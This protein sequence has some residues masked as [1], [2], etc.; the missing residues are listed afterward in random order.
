VLRLVLIA[1]AL[2]AVGCNSCSS[3]AV[4]DA[5]A[6]KSRDDVSPVYAQNVTPDPVAQRTCHALHAIHAERRA[7]CCGG[8]P[9]P[10]LAESECVK[11]LSQ[12]L[13]SKAVK[14]DDAKLTA[15]EAAQK[16]Q[17]D[18]CDWPSLD[19]NL[20]AAACW[21][22][23]DGTLAS[24]AVCRSSLECQP[25]LHCGG[26]GPT[27]L[28]HCS[29]PSKPP[30]ACAIA[31]DPLASYTAQRGDDLHPECDGACERHRCVPALDAGQSC[32]SSLQCG[33]NRH[34]AFDGGCAEGGLAR[35]G[36]ACVAGG[37]G[38][39]LRCIGGSCAPAKKSGEACEHDSECTGACSKDAGV[40]APRCR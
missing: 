6:K 39:D 12:S 8:A 2:S 20:P 19:D 14:I 10:N 4:P 9:G 18:G 36:E 13:Q 33:A 24:G 25:G 3:S 30:S 15:C 35:A 27:D 22:L 21:T 34:C 29:A 40:C 23:I 7:A 26:G 5:G 1:F 38:D 17:Y 31:V 37:C 32:V 16:K 11:M 28:G